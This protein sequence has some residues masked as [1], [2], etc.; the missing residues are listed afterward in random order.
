MCRTVGYKI[1]SPVI[2][3]LS[4]D[5]EKRL[6]DLNLATLLISIFQTA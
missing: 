1:L 4:P 6:R 3:P 5:T 2:A